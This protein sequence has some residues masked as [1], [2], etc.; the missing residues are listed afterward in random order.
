MVVH[1]FYPLNEILPLIGLNRPPLKL[2]V[3]GKIYSIKMSG[4][5]LEC[6]K[7]NQMCV[8]CGIKGN[9]WRLESSP[10]SK[11]KHAINQLHSHFNLYVYYGDNFTLMTQDH[12]LPKSRGGSDMIFNLQTMCSKCNGAKGNSI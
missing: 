1:G 3:E 2:D 8:W 9:V 5:R 11:K 6:L 4:N 12:I 7:R 10:P